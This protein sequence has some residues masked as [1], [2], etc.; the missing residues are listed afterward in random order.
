MRLLSSLFLITFS[1]SL[2]AA[3]S[4]DRDHQ[5]Q[6]CVNQCET[7]NQ[8]IAGEVPHDFPLA[9]RL[10]RW[11]CLDDC[12]Y[13]C[14][15]TMT[16]FAVESGVPIKQYYGKWPFWRSGGMQEPASVL[17][18]LINLLLHIW[19]RGE[20]KRSIP[21]AHPMKRFYLTWSLVSCNAWV[22]SV[23]FHTRGELVVTSTD[24]EF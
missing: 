10:T 18:S 12:K 9:M 2:V 3:S 4:G 24:L 6:R 19:G 8:C 5:F 7:R 23:V 21:D 16:D 22:W 20:V 15:H 1:S 13:T 11:T 17:F 14:M